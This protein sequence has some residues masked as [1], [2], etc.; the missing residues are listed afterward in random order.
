MVTLISFFF[1]LFFA[2][3]FSIVFSYFIMD[4]DKDNLNVVLIAILGALISFILDHNIGS[5]NPS[6]TY[7]LG[8][9]SVVYLSKNFIGNFDK[10]EDLLLFFPGV[11]GL[12]I[13]FG[14]I[15]EVIVLMF[16]LYMVRSSFGRIN[17]HGYDDEDEYKVE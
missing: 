7:G 1:L 5:D 11:I 9:F 15:F 10:T 4:D 3:L 6:I 17:S 13:G 16:F 8:L 14:F 2:T 12:L